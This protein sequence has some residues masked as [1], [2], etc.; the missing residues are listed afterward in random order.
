M[1]G[2]RKASSKIV[3]NVHNNQPKKKKL[4]VIKVQTLLGEFMA[5][6][7]FSFSELLLFPFIVSRYLN[8]SGLE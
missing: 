7:L 8:T 3:H 5:V 4:G 6:H 2:R 1:V